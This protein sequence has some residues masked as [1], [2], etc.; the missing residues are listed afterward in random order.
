MSRKPNWLIL[1]EA[2]RDLIETGKTVFTRKE[3]TLQARKIDPSRSEASLD[4][5]IDLVT[6]NSNSKDKYRDPDKLFLYRI[7]RGRYTIYNPE[8]HGPIENY[9]YY[10]PSTVRKEFLAEIIKKLEEVGYRAHENKAS[11]K[12]LSPNIV[13][14][15]NDKRIGVWVVDPSQDP[16][17]QLRTLAYAIGS[18]I[19]NKNFSEYLVILPQNLL[20]KISLGTRDQ[21]SKLGVK[22]AYLKEEKRYSLL[23]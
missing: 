1:K 14:E 12:P 21:L 16:I 13:A 6:I 4:F 23:L 15:I 7:D 22:L 3:L 9:L 2:A 19:L 17:S 10:R 18:S 20:S 5:E 8:V 11:N